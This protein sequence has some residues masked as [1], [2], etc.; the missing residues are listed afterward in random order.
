MLLNWVTDQSPHNELYL[1]CI[2][3]YC[4]QPSKNILFKINVLMGE[5]GDLDATLCQSETS[6]LLIALSVSST[7]TI[8]EFVA[9]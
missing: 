7:R 3:K 6:Q 9:F 4:L 8:L 5:G 1:I 2:A